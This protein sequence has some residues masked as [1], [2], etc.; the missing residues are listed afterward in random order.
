[1]LCATMEACSLWLI[2]TRP[3]MVHV[4]YAYSSLYNTCILEEILPSM[5]CALRCSTTRIL[6]SRGIPV[7]VKGIP[8]VSFTLGYSPP[9][10]VPQHTIL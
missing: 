6:G 1:M 2:H 8:G 7:L 9:K 10:G 5:H 3:Q 4:L